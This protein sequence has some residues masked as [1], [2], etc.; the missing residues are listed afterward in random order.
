MSRDQSRDF[1]VPYG[2][3]ALYVNQAALHR[4]SMAQ[5]QCLQYPSDE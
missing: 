3:G 1:L 4:H 2:P 5:D